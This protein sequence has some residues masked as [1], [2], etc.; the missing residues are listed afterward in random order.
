MKRSTKIDTTMLTRGLV[1]GKGVPQIPH[2]ASSPGLNS[3]IDQAG[4]FVSPY[5]SF[6]SPHTNQAVELIISVHQN[7]T[8]IEVSAF[9]CTE[10]P[11]PAVPISN[12]KNSNVAY[13][14]TA[15]YPNFRPIKPKATKITEYTR[16]ASKTANKM[17]NH[18]PKSENLNTASPGPK[19]PVTNAHNKMRPMK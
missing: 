14:K 8:D 1:V 16:T 19:K 2:S 12:M 3:P 15:T 7:D 9:I 10:E 5:N 11:L 6:Q 18:I 13:K 4:S 17:P